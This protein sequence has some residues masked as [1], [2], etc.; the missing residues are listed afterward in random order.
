M[1]GEEAYAGSTIGDALR[2]IADHHYAI[3]N[4]HISAAEHDVLLR[5]A[6]LLEPPGSKRSD[7]LHRIASMRRRG[8]KPET[9]ASRLECSLATVRRSLRSIV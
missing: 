6:D 2:A 5:A 1:P 7:R 4:R 9:I 3:A 8:L